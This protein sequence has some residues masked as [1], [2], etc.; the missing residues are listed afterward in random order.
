MDRFHF[1][2]RGVCLGVALVELDLKGNP[3]PW[4]GQRMR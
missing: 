4:S 2:R 3:D 1:L